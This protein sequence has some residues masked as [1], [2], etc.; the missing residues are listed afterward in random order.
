MRHF[1]HSCPVAALALSVGVPAPA[2]ALVT[3]SSFSHT[4]FARG[5]RTSAIAVAIASIAVTA[6][7][8]GPAASRAQVASPKKFHRQLGPMGL[9][10]NARFVTYS[11]CNVACWLRARRWL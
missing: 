7:L 10:D 1:L 8:H 4:T 5:L 2:A 11:A 3:L 6:D 9:V